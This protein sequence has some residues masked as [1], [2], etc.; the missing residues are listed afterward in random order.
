VSHVMLQATFSQNSSFPRTCRMLQNP[1]ANKPHMLL[2]M[3]QGKAS[4]KLGCW[5]P[6]PSKSK[7]TAGRMVVMA[8]LKNSDCC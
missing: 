7:V 2:G 8:Q 4:P 5:L 3:D 1:L 6:P